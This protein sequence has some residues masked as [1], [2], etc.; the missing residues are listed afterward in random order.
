MLSK[1]KKVFIT[2]VLIILII[3]SLDYLF[4]PQLTAFILN[5]YYFSREKTPE[6]Y[7]VPADRIPNPNAIDLTSKPRL[8]CKWFQFKTPWRLLS[9]REVSASNTIFIFSDEDVRKA[10]IVE[11][12]LDE[13]LFTNHPAFSDFRQ[14][15]AARDLTSEYSI[16][17]FCLRT[18]PEDVPFLF[19]RDKVAITT[20]MLFLKGG[21]ARPGTEIFRFPIND[22][23]CIQFR[24]PQKPSQT[25]VLLFDNAD[26]VFQI[27]FIPPSSQ[28]E[29]DSILSSI[30]FL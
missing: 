3:G 1:K 10:I 18:T 26:R 14:L 2:I 16:T 8:S 5:K 23:K 13:L 25:V 29:I 28:D 22:L 27:S 19:P 12:R 11:K 9:K 15:S 21:Y 4:S 24:N 17:D 7:A 30:T 20:M 6:L